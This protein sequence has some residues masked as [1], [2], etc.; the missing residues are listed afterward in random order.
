MR[1]YPASCGYTE[2]SAD[3]HGR[4]WNTRRNHWGWEHYLGDLYGSASVSKYASPADPKAK[5][6][7]NGSW[8]NSS[9]SSTP[10]PFLPRLQNHKDDGGDADGDPDRHFPRQRL[11]E[12]KR[13]DEDGRERLEDSQDRCL[14]RA[15][16]TR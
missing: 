6:P 12:Q 9:V 16:I 11:S 3:N 13:A 1:P 15:D 8:R 5:P 2:T 14:G 7:G 10:L 4:V